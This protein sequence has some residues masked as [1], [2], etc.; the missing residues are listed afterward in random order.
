MIVTSL[1]LDLVFKIISTWKV[2]KFKSN[3][4]QFTLRFSNFN[5]LLAVKEI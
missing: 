5:F 1:T 3:L 2:K 4:S